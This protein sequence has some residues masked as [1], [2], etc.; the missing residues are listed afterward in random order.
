MLEL[1]LQDGKPWIE[2]GTLFSLKVM[3]TKMCF[4][5]FW[6][7]ISQELLQTTLNFILNFLNLEIYHKNQVHGSDHALSNILLK[8]V[9]IL[10]FHICI[11]S[12]SLVWF[13]RIYSVEKI[14]FMNQIL[15]Y[16]QVFTYK[17]PEKWN[18]TT[19]YFN[20]IVRIKSTFFCK[21]SN[22]ENVT[23]PWNN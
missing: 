19:I 5:K 17:T 13:L 12:L 2:K 7:K 3:V 9:I 23:K 1:F 10:T 14:Q 6:S 18:S 22:M 4:T 15:I 16:N 8:C 21:F 20:N 11:K